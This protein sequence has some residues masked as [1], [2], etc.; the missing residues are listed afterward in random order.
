[1]LFNLSSSCQNSALQK[2]EPQNALFQQHAFLL[3]RSMKFDM[4]NEKFK[5]RIQEFIDTCT[6][7]NFALEKRV[8]PFDT[9]NNK[10]SVI[11][12]PY[13]FNNDFSQ[14]IIIVVKRSSDSNN[15]PLDYVHFILGKNDKEKWSL[16][17]KE[18]YSRSF[19]YAIGHPVL[20]DTEIFLRV[21][22]TLINDGY[23]ASNS[24][25]IDDDFFLKDW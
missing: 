11:V 4:L 7:F 14:A 19:S 2:L 1:M 10:I 12:Q 3:E 8:N 9:V 24:L 13:L 5:F 18:R 16:G 21:L 23:M 15:K 17:L 20:S 6:Q 22:R 25:I